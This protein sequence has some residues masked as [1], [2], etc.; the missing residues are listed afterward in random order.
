MRV[1]FAVPASQLGGH[2][3]IELLTLDLHLQ[4]QPSFRSSLHFP[5]APLQGHD[6]EHPP[7][8][9]GLERGVH[10]GGR[11]CSAWRGEL[12]E[13]QAKFET[14]PVDHG[15]RRCALANA[16]NRRASKDSRFAA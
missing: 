16:T 2:V 8:R 13:L 7:Q 6:G 15:K 5:N 1:V 4:S 9:L 11:F 14:I 12:T 10:R 3:I